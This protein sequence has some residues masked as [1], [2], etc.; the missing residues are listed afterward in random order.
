MKKPAQPIGRRRFLGAI[1]A[2]VAAT[3]TLPAVVRGQRGAAAPPKFGKDVLKCAE[4]IDGL[5]FT[6][7]EEDMSA[8]AVGRNLDSYEEL[9]KL[10][11]PL[12]TEPAVAFRPYLKKMKTATQGRQARWAGS[13]LKSLTGSWSSGGVF[14]HPPHQT[15]QP[16]QRGYFS[17]VAFLT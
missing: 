2:A 7:A 12:D 10:D 3:V 11:V 1:P 17:I 15:C 6:D 8:A 4:Q 5:H 9:R 16:H 14:P 13:G